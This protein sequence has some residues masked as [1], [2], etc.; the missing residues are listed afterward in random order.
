M[1]K[2]EEDHVDHHDDMGHALSPHL[3]IAVWVV[4]MGFTGLTVFC[5]SLGL[6]SQASFTVAMVIATIKAGLVMSVF[7]HLWWDKRVNLFAFLGSFLFV[8]LFIGMALTDKSEYNHDLVP[9]PEPTQAAQQPATGVQA[10]P[11]K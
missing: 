9:N 1:S 8:M 2:K 7:M 3:L 11:P 4:L 10:T 6:G 5:A